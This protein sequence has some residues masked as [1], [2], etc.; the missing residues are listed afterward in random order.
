MKRYLFRLFHQ[1]PNSFFESC[2]LNTIIK[3]LIT[4]TEDIKNG[5][6]IFFSKFPIML[7]AKVVCTVKYE[8]I[9]FYFYLF[10]LLN[11]DKSRTH[12]SEQITVLFF[13]SIHNNGGHTISTHNQTGQTIRNCLSY[14]ILNLCNEG[15]VNIDLKETH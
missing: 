2:F 14:N 6:K 4:E 10:S 9:F 15:C 3:N 7:Q 1:F 11:K 8:Y 12:K 5:D 13:R